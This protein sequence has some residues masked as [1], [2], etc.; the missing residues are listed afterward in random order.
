MPPS[1]QPADWNLNPTNYTLTFGDPTGDEAES[2][3][4]QNQPL[5]PSNIPRKNNPTGNNNGSTDMES[6]TDFL[7]NT[8]GN[9]LTQGQKHNKSNKTSS[10][11]SQ[12]YM[13][14]TDSSSIGSFDT[15]KTS[16]NTQLSKSIQTSAITSTDGSCSDIAQTKERSSQQ[17][18]IYYI[19][20]PNYTL[21][22]LEFL[23]KD[24]NAKANLNQYQKQSN[25]KILLPPALHSSNRPQSSGA[26]TG[27]SYIR[28]QSGGGSHHRRPLSLNDLEKL[29]NTTIQDWDS[30]EVLLPRSIVEML[31]ESNT[32]NKIIDGNK[33]INCHNKDNRSQEESIQKP[34]PSSGFPLKTMTVD[35]CN[36]QLRRRQRDNSEN[37][38]DGVGGS[39]DRRNRIRRRKGYSCTDLPDIREMTEEITKNLEDYNCVVENNGL[40]TVTAAEAQ[41]SSGCYYYSSQYNAEGGG[42]IAPHNSPLM[43]GIGGKW[44]GNSNIGIRAGDRNSSCSSTTSITSTSTTV[45][46]GDMERGIKDKLL[47]IF[48]SAVY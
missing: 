29:R 6:S 3:T 33:Q 23:K 15:A 17:S 42:A 48:T 32:L 10:I 8:N 7:M 35:N 19:C 37:S 14:T 13:N 25:K 1:T 16:G 9:A 40:L 45:Q 41:A 2:P 36:V 11:G 34:S 38:S 12:E 43:S 47:D 39:S 30:L 20:Y 46:L 21:P 5:R 4:T 28:Q 18:P 27:H 31:S 24:E 26:P 44:G 22:N